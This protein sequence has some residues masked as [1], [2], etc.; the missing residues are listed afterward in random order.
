MLWGWGDSPHQPGGTHEV[1]M[2]LGQGVQKSA[3]VDGLVQLWVQSV[4]L[5]MVL[6][7]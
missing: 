5:R 2:G 4:K 6:L 3:G 7:C 1:R